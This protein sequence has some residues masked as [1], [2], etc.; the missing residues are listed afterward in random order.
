[1]R[2]FGRIDPAARRAAGYRWFNSLPTAQAV[3]CLTDAGLEPGLA[4][5]L[6]GRGPLAEGWPDAMP[7]PAASYQA[8]VTMF[9]GKPG[10]S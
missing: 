10:F 7:G 5:A 9:E 8:L 4:A 2:L 6:A 1:V 3:R